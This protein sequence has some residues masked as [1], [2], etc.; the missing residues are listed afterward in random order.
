M[1]DEYTLVKV[2]LMARLLLS[3]WLPLMWRSG[4]LRKSGLLG[5]EGIKACRRGYYLVLYN[6]CIL[7][8]F[9]LNLNFC[10]S[11]I[12]W[13]FTLNSGFDLYSVSHQPWILLFC[14][15]IKCLIS[16]L[17]VSYKCTETQTVNAYVDYN[18][19][20]VWVPFKGAH[21]I[22]A[23]KGKC[24]YQQSCVS[25]TSNNVLFPDEC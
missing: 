10:H 25:V 11:Y 13:L 8:S 17:I 3:K 2:L 21:L 24:I 23:I 19:T 15:Q 9:I 5:Q 7:L 20:H 14:S 16:T 6:A 1:V 18:Y 22:W 4:L 12:Y